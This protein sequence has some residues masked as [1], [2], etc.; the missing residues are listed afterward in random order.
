MII[1]MCT[2]PIQ[3]THIYIGII[4]VLCYTMVCD[5]AGPPVSA[6]LQLNTI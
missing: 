3:H 5:V 2:V 4:L 1:V 6:F